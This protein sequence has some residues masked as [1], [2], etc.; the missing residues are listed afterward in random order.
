M[1]PEERKK[2]IEERDLLHESVVAARQAGTRE[3]LEQRYQEIQKELPE[4]EAKM[5]KELKSTE[6]RYKTCLED[7]KDAS[8]AVQ[9]FSVFS[10]DYH[11][12]DDWKEKAQNNLK[13]IE[14]ERASIQAPFQKLQKEKYKIE[15]HCYNL[16]NAEKVEELNKAILSDL[17]KDLEVH[18]V[19][20]Q[21]ELKK[22]LNIELKIK[23]KQEEL[24][25][26][27]E[28][29][30]TYKNSIMGKLSKIVMGTT[31]KE[32]EM[33]NKI[34]LAKEKIINYTT[35]EMPEQ[36]CKTN[37]AEKLLKDAE[38]SLEVE[39][40][41]QEEIKQETPTMRDIRHAL[42]LSDKNASKQ[43]AVPNANQEQK[44]QTR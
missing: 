17:N 33:L 15:V 38:K 42:E 24:A 32:L 11:A 16:D 28:E 36:K 10:G 8:Y 39:K 23:A 3:S 9:N 29:H 5:K 6:K 43:G 20:Y 41:R 40:K 35:K 2:L 34:S 7:L 1:T 4:A 37:E 13:E 18:Q 22:Q 31:N 44:S 26:A 14:D 27:Q 25:K 30:S 19:A 21:A 12:W